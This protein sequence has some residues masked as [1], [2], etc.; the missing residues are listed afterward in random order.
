[1]RGKSG[2]KTNSRIVKN[3]LNNIENLRIKNEY[4]KGITFSKTLK[5]IQI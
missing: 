5:V 1:M 4:L 3:I 2:S